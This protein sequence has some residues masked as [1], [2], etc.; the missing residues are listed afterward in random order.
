MIINP[1]N[2]RGMTFMVKSKAASNKAPGILCEKG[3]TTFLSVSK[4]ME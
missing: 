4:N 1:G 3:N 2:R